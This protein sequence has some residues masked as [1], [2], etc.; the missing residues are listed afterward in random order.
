MKNIEDFPR[1]SS[2][3]NGLCHCWNRSINIY[4]ILTNDFM[5]MLR[6]RSTAT[7]HMWWKEFP[8]LYLPGEKEIVMFAAEV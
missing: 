2:K 6:F 4:W 8:A 1:E 7:V 5:F 3:N